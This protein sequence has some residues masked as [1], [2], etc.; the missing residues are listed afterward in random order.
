MVLICYLI[1]AKG[2]LEGFGVNPTG[3]T[4]PASHFIPPVYDILECIIAQVYEYFQECQ[5]FVERGLVLISLYCPHLELLEET[6]LMYYF[7]Q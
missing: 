1:G 4:N 5:G 2:I 3:F 7:R 6:S